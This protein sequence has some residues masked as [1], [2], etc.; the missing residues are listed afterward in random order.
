MM[1]GSYSHLGNKQG[2]VNSF[3]LLCGDCVK[4]RV[5]TVGVSEAINFAVWVKGVLNEWI[6]DK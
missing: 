1:L 2:F 5:L 3:L 6:S 4:V